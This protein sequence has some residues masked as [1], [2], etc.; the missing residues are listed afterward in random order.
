MPKH[1]ALADPTGLSRLRTV[2]EYE[3]THNDEK[4]VALVHERNVL[5]HVREHRQ[6]AERDLQRD[7]HDEHPRRT[8]DR[9]ARLRG[10]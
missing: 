3:R 8:L 5:V 2:R 7:R 6:R 4:R 1:R 9:C 10:P